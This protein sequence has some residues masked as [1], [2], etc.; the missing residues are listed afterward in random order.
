MIPMKQ[1][2]NK[3]PWYIRTW[4]GFFLGVSALIL[5]LTLYNSLFPYKIPTTPIN[6][7][8]TAPYGVAALI[9]VLRLRKRLFSLI[10]ALI[11]LCGWGFNTTLFY[12]VDGS[13]SGGYELISGIILY[14]T[15]AVGLFIPLIVS[16]WFGNCSRVLLRLVWGALTMALFGGV[17]SILAEPGTFLDTVNSKDHYWWMFAYNLIFLGYLTAG[18]KDRY[19]PQEAP[20]SYRAS[21]FQEKKAA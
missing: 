7:V 2:L 1:V 17:I 8:I 18:W 9:L 12:P 14:L 4:L 10:G 15:E 5:S 6:W 11:V 13:P 3:T 21:E 20:E 19:V 16:R